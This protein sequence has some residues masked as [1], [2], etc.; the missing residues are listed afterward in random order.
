MKSF[1]VPWRKRIASHKIILG[2]SAGC[3][4]FF[5]VQ[6]KADKY[7]ISSF[8]PLEEKR[9]ISCGARIVELRDKFEA[10]IPSIPSSGEQRCSKCLGYSR[11]KGRTTLV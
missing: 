4:A 10:V 5:L 3:C 8:Q 1:C 6:R 9:C 7:V 2:C 11:I